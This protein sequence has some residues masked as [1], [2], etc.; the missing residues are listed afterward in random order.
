MRKRRRADAWELG[1]G[2][3]LVQNRAAFA[4]ATA[5]AEEVCG[6][7]AFRKHLSKLIMIIRE[8]VPCLV[9]VKS[10]K[11]VLAAFEVEDA[12]EQVSTI[13]NHSLQAGL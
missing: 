6:T 4:P 10:G 9:N 7:A 11:Q 12:R 2:L 3:R 8:Q 5:L 1:A 13:R